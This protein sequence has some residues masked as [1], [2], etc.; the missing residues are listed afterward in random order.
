MA[1]YQA[2]SYKEC[3]ADL[4][5]P[6]CPDCGAVDCER[7]V[8]SQYQCSSGFEPGFRRVCDKCGRMNCLSIMKETKYE[9]NN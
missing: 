8:S 1:P 9:D 2:T 3:K 6:A 4:S 7:A 5:L